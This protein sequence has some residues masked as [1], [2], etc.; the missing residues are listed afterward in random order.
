MNDF[1][2]I[3][4]ILLV[5]MLIFACESK[6][7]EPFNADSLPDNISFEMD[8]APRFS[9]NCT[10]CHNGTRPPNLNPD[11][12]YVELTSGGYI[13]T[14]DPENSK[15]YQEIDGGGMTQYASDEDRAYILEWIKQGALDN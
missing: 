9:A 8:I 12:A 10:K 2:N 3:M 11:E 14:S 7:R 6:Q 5:A 15:L 4:W 1:R 13:N